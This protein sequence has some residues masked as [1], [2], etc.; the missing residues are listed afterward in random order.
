LVNTLKL[1]AAN[2]ERMLALQFDRFYQ[3]PKDAFSVFRALLQ[4]PGVVRSAGPDHLEVLLQR[5]DSPKVAE[6]LAMLIL[7]LNH[8]TPRMLDGGP[9]LSFHQLYVNQTAPSTNPHYRSSET[10]SAKLESLHAG[11]PL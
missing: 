8:R 7:D 2:A 10:S 4:L 9:A 5:P 3:T 1:T 6:A 11:D